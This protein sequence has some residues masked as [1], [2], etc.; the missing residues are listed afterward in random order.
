MIQIFGK[1]A[2]TSQTMKSGQQLK[3]KLL[4]AKAR[5]QT[6]GQD[7]MNRFTDIKQNEFFVSE[8]F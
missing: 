5:G 7:S 1:G 8:N 2:A 6:L 4:V 3:Y